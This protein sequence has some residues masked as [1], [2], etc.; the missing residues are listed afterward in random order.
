MSRKMFFEFSNRPSSYKKLSYSEKLVKINR[1]IR[2]GD[3]TKVAE[4]TGYSTQYVSDVLLGKV[5]NERI[6]NEAYD[7]TR[8]RL[9]NS[10]KI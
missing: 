4:T 1:K 6:L 10:K 9:E 2:T 5:E 7:S 3:V 8:G